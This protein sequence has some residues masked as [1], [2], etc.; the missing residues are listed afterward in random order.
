MDNLVVWTSIPVSDLD[1]AIA[2]Y[3]RVV[4]VAFVRPPGIDGIAVPDRSLEAAPDRIVALNLYVGGEPGS[5]GSMVFLSSRGDIDAMLERVR[6]AGGT[7]DMEKEYGGEMIGW[8]AYFIDTEGNRVGI[9]Q[10]GP[11]PA[12]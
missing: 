10:W 9:E 2:F 11:T 7:V 4:G 6:E 3:S 1:R 8:T 5:G 12:L